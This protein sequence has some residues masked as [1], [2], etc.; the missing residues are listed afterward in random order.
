[1]INSI[2]KTI[3]E[4]DVDI[5]ESQLEEL[6]KQYLLGEIKLEQ[7]RGEINRLRVK[8]DLRRLA[9]KIKIGSSEHKIFDPKIKT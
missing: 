1:M 9:S 5:N 8:L 6:T 4:K 2:D 3:H 7:Y